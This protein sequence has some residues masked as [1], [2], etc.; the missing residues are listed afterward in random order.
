VD[1]RLILRL[2][3]IPCR[4]PVNQPKDPDT[5]AE[6]EAAALAGLPHPTTLRGHRR[7]QWLLRHEALA[8]RDEHLSRLATCHQ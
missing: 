6:R 2:L 8:E 5:E 3:G 7:H 4:A 1:P